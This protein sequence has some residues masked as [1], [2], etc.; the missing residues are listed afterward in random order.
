MKQIIPDLT[1][2]ETLEALA[3]LEDYGKQMAHMLAQIEAML[4]KEGATH[5]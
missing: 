4:E 3:L 2:R 1:E 5:H